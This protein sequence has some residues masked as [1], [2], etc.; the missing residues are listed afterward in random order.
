MLAGHPRYQRVA[1][2]FDTA[3]DPSGSGR[4]ELAAA[5]Q[6]CDAGTRAGIACTLHTRPARHTWQGAAQA[7]ADA[8]P[9][10]TARGGAPPAHP[11][12]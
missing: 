9:W 5:R 6:L 12:A 11:A 2:W 10:M 7:F 8:L 1:G 3:G 4:T